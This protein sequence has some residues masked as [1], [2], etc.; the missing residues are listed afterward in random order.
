MSSEVASTT[1]AAGPTAAESKSATSHRVVLITGGN[2]GLGLEFVRQLLEEEEHPA[3]QAFPNDT[4]IIATARDPAGA[5]ELKGLQSKFP[6]RLD[7]QPLEV[8]NDA[9]IQALVQYVTEKYGR[10]DMLLNN[11]GLAEPDPQA[12]PTSV[13]K[14][15]AL[16]VL[17]TNTIAPIEITKAFLSLLRATLHYNDNVRV[18]YIS[19]S[20]GSIGALANAYAPSYRASKAALNM[21]VRCFAFEVPELAFAL[22]HPGWVQTDMGKRGNRMPPLDIKSSIKGCLKVIQNMHK[23]K[24][25]KAIEAFDGTTWIW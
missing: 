3:I 8:D 21:Y 18:A 7:I 9:Q 4:I 11:A 6:D 19:S 17:T 24:S 16:K 13:S 1:A 25:A 14:E 12:T 15:L 22:I 20:M 5:T 23:T 2:R 10:L